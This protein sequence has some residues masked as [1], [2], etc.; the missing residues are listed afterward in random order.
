MFSQPVYWL[1]RKIC[2]ILKTLYT[3]NPLGS[4]GVVAL[5]NIIDILRW[6]YSPF[7]GQGEKE[8]MACFP[9]L[10]C[11]IKALLVT[12]LSHQITSFRQCDHQ[13]VNFSKF[14]SHGPFHVFFFFLFL[15]HRLFPILLGDVAFLLQ[16][17]WY[18]LMTACDV[19][20][21]FEVNWERSL[22]NSVFLAV[23]AL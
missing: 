6:S 19:G 9:V 13:N 4:R 8:R 22:W 12:L 2:L 17:V 20:I 21:M 15:I 7:G 16:H 10:P 3:P 23:Y 18:R 11:A 5:L 14:F 1:V